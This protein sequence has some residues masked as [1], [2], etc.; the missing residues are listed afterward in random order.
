MQDMLEPEDIFNPRHYDSVHRRSDSAETLPAWCYTSKKFYER[1]RERIFFKFWNCIGHQSRVPEIGSYITFDFC[2]VPLIVVR[3]EDRQLRAF[4]N[5]CPH[6]GSEIMQ[7]EGTC[8]VLKC[9]YHAWAFELNGDLMA[10]PLFEE[11]ATFRMADHGL[12][13]IKLDLW[14]GF[15]W[16]NLDP[17]AQDL[18][19]YLGDLPERTKPWAAQDMVCVSRRAYPVASNWKL[20]LENFSDGYHVPFVHQHTLN[21]KKVSKRDFHDPTV[22][23]GN[24]LMHYTYFDGTRRARASEEAARARPASRTQDRHLLPGRPRQ[25]HDELRYRHGLGDRGLSRRSGEVHPGD[26]EPG[27]QE[28]G[29]AAGF[30]GDLRAVHGQRRYRAQRGRDRLRAPAARPQLAL[31]WP[32]LLHAAGQAGPRL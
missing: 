10:T 32:R 17:D 9:P 16:I 7:G 28:H 1:E 6:R 18:A 14:A 22:H 31:Q 27:A 8:R 5:S 20:Y 25:H 4:I 13:Q 2:G 15:M 29:R 26:L 19:S 24:Y 30:Q 3:G 12:R 11:S 21:F 23:L